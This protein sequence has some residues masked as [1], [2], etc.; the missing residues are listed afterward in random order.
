LP[1]F[2]MSERSGVVVSEDELSANPR[3]RSARLR[4]AVRTDAP[5]WPQGETLLPRA[6]SLG[7]LRKLAS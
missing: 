7:D 2:K 5:E 4:Y 6:P 1:S 3:A